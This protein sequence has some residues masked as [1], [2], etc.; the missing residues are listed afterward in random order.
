MSCGNERR[1][2][3]VPAL[4]PAVRERLSQIGAV[5]HR[6]CLECDATQHLAAERRTQHLREFSATMS[7]TR[8]TYHAWLDQIEV[9][10][11]ECEALLDEHLADPSAV[12]P[13]D[14][15]LIEVGNERKLLVIYG[16]IWPRE[17]WPED[18]PY[19]NLIALREWYVI[20]Q[21]NF[22]AGIQTLHDVRG[23]LAGQTEG[24]GGE[25]VDE[26]KNLDVEPNVDIETIG[27][28]EQP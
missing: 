16:D 15:T 7:Q 8:H 1:I 22:P 3:Q 21:Q 4:S 27:E 17:S 6:W 28:E 5:Y 18:V 19:L 23:R 2:S 26:L 25:G 11:A 9:V 14:W 12:T 13:D 10:E 24:F 20:R